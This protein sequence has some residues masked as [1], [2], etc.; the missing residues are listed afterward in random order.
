MLTRIAI[1]ST[2][3]SLALVGCANPQFSVPYTQAGYP[4]A[5]DINKRVR[6]ELATLV[7]KKDGF[8]F[9]PVLL[10]G[11]YRVAGILSL[12]SKLSAGV[13]PSLSFPGAG[14]VTGGVVDIDV[15]PNVARTIERTGV[16]YLN[17]SLGDIY[18]HTGEAGADFTCPDA[19]SDLAGKLGIADLVATS[20]PLPIQQDA[21]APGGQ[22]GGTIT[23]TTNVGVTGGPTWILKH[24]KGPGSG[25]ANA[26]NEYTNKLTL[27]FFQQPLGKTK[28]QTDKLIRAE[29]LQVLQ[30]IIDQDT[31][32]QLST[33]I[34]SQ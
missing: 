26:S 6:C 23:F 8:P 30:S 11:N 12:G 19:T 4:D 14:A 25:F 22:F 34:N 31:S 24:F 13:K 21:G 27:A 20:M 7:S 1:A 5:S 16:T 15:A 3:C 10:Q 18:N 28:A 32:R 2:I 9:R 33:I 17:Y 29:A